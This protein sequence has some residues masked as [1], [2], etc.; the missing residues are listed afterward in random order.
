[1]LNSR[2]Q[3]P[4]QTKLSVQRVML[5]V[6]FAF[7]DHFH[8]VQRLVVPDQDALVFN[9][10]PTIIAERADA[11]QTVSRYHFYHFCFFLFR[12]TVTNLLY[13]DGNVVTVQGFET[14]PALTLRKKSPTGKAH[15]FCRRLL[16][17][18]SY[19]FCYHVTTYI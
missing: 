12:V 6:T 18:P 2:C 1:M 3:L 13:V 7:V 4:R 14:N 15:I 17:K 19:Y 11:I 8:I 10:Q 5:A 9:P 16:M